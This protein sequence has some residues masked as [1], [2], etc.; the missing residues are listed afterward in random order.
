MRVIRKFLL[1]KRRSLNQRLLLLAL[2]VCSP[3]SFA[4]YSCSG[5]VG[6][7]GIDAGGDLTL[8]LAGATPIHKICNVV[9]QGT[10]VTAIASCKVAYAALLSARLTGKSMTIYYNENGLTCGTLTPWAA[11]PGTYFVQGPD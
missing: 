1:Y 11:V 5:T 9:A 8:A 2:S 3:A 10:Y 6:F 4:N 7:L